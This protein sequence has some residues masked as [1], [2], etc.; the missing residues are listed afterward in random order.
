[1]RKKVVEKDEKKRE[2][3]KESVDRRQ[4]SKASG[5]MK[6][7]PPMSTPTSSA[8]MSMVAL[9]APSPI[10]PSG[11]LSEAFDLAS[12]SNDKATGVEQPEPEELEP[13]FHSVSF[14]KIR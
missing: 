13:G 3:K 5:P 10:L 8:M 7:S 4:S 11:G 12:A 14:A 1:M 6:S 9:G 2:K